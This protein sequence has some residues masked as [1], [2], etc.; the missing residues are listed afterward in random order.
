M[1]PRFKADVP[2]PKQACTW[3]ARDVGPSFL[4]LLKHH[5]TESSE[6][7]GKTFYAVAAQASYEELCSA[8]SKCTSYPFLRS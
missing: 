7:Y 6:I 4:A 8:L 5:K 2:N 1:A 3:V